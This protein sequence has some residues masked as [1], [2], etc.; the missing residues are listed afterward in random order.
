MYFYAVF[1]VFLPPEWPMGTN[2]V[3]QWLHILLLFFIS[4]EMVMSKW[5]IYFYVTSH[6]GKQYD[7][8][9]RDAALEANYY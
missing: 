9:G 6:L 1:E 3:P 4:L 2:S 8:L 7:I 5:D